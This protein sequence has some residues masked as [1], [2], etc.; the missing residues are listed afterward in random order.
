M[1]R[2]YLS[3]TFILICP[4]RAKKTGYLL[5]EAGLRISAHAWDK[6]LMWITRKDQ[7][8]S[9]YFTFL[10]LREIRI[11]NKMPTFILTNSHIRTQT[12]DEFK[13]SS[14]K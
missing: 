6:L 9:G 13:N 11:L 2:N 12:Y 3:P 7:R 4:E 8:D 10:F 1:E 14:Q 5:P